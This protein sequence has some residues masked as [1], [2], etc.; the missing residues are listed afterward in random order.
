MKSNFKMGGVFYVTCYDKNG[1]M[2]W[3][4]RSKNL[5]VNVGLEHVLDT[6]FSLGGETAHANYYLGMTDASPTIVAG[7]TLSSHVGWNE[8]IYVTDYS[9]L[10][11]QEFTE[12]RTGQTVDNSASKAVFSIVSTTTIGGA[13][14]CSVDTGTAGMLLAASAFANG[15]KPVTAGD[16]VE[17]QYDFSI[18]SS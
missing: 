10:A 1:K 14:I 8:V 4:D 5:V 12:V 2:K 15:D 3:K 9:E 6:I 7:D 16:T 17:V 11:R 18:T 13:F